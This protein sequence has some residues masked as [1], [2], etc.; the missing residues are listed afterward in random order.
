LAFPQESSGAVTEQD[1]SDVTR[2]WGSRQV[3]DLAELAGNEGAHG[4]LK[5]AIRIWIGDQ[6]SSSKPGTRS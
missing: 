4:G 6:P 3:N 5:G 2:E 1:R